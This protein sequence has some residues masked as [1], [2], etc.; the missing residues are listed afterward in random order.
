MDNKI[1]QLHLLSVKSFVN[2]VDEGIK[3][4]KTIVVSK[5]DL[6]YTNGY[7]VRNFYKN[8]TNLIN[9]YRSNLEK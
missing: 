2:N 1:F 4:G 9:F 5:C 6:I 3:N 8:N 7:I